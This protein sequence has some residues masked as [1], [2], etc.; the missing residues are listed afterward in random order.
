MVLIN[1]KIISSNYKDNK[2]DI[3]KFDQLNIDL[4]NIQNRTIKQPKVQE[5]STF[6]LIKCS[7]INFFKKDDCKSKFTTEILPTLNRE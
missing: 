4:Q 6:N 2:N 1:G 5:T 3:V 7:E